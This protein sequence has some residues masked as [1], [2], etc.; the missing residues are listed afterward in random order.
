MAKEAW[1]IKDLLGLSFY[2]SLYIT[3]GKQG[4]KLEAGADAEATEGCCF[5]PHTLWLAQPVLLENQGPPAQG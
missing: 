3:E 5:L 4:R 2:V 1:G